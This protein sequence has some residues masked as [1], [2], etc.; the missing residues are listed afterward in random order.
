MNN[1]SSFSLRSAHHPKSHRR[2]AGGMPYLYVLWEC[3]V[4]HGPVSC[5]LVSQ[6]ALGLRLHVPIPLLYSTCPTHVAEP[7]PRCLS[8]QGEPF[9]SVESI[10]G[11]PLASLQHLLSRAFGVL[12][13]GEM[14]LLSDISCVRVLRLGLPCSV[15]LG[16]ESSLFWQ[17]GPNPATWYSNPAEPKLIGPYASDTL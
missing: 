10:L 13:P 3:R 8:R 4:E 2:S 1:H 12:T 14:P 5:L 16:I 11:S 7:K 15:C 17:R 9:L 6:A